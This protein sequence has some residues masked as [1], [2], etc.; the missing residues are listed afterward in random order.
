[1]EDTAG[2]PGLSKPYNN[3]SHSTSGRAK[4]RVSGQHVHL[5]LTSEE[6]HINTAS[7]A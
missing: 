1:M 6:V 7:A 4:G 5:L 3:P 2:L